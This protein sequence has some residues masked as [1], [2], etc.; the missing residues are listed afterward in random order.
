MPSVQI[1]MFSGRTPTQKKDLAKLVTQAVVD[2]L[3]VRPEGVRLRINE[4]EKY[5]SAEGGVLREEP[6]AN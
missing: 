6:P 2:A 1:D 5:H 3:N 4:I